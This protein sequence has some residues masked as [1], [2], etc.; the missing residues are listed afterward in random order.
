MAFPDPGTLAP[1]EIWVNP[2]S[3]YGYVWSETNERWEV[4]N[5]PHSG[6]RVSTTP[7]QLEEG[8][9]PVCEGEFWYDE[10]SRTLKIYIDGKWVAAGYAMSS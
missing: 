4:V 3:G 5:G 10:T 1:G 2:D 8:R 9:K 7:P 6:I